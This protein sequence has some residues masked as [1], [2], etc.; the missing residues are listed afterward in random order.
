MSGDD[1]VMAATRAS[2]PWLSP[3]AT[4]AAGFGALFYVR[5]FG[6]GVPNIIPPCPFHTLT[7]WWC[8]GCGL[9]RGTRALMHGH[10]QQ[11]LGFN[12]FTPLVLAALIYT[13][14]TWAV[15]RIGGPSLPAMSR[16]PRGVVWGLCSAG[17][18]FTVARN[19]PVASLAALAP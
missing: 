11:A 19:L 7:G 3:I 14:L 18:I 4:A 9:T 10:L 1:V 13:W 17:L 2:R 16:L 5:S 15:P 12:L 8:P 6:H